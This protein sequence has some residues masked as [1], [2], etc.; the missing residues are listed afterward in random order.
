VL[1]CAA[2][3]HDI[4]AYPLAASDGPYTADGRRFALALLD[5]FGWPEMRL[6]A[7]G[8]AIEQHHQLVDQWE[9]GPEAELMRRADLADVSGG[10]VNF[11]LSRGW[12]RGL[13]RAAP[14][15]GIYGELARIVGRM[16]RDRPDTRPKIFT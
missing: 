14:R 4:G 11:G 12:L 15:A 6:K 13:F 10:L 16:A 3:L 2:L 1:L 9:L 5:R 7:C 8:D